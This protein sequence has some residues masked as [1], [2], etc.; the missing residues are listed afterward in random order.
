[1]TLCRFEPALD[2]ASRLISKI[3]RQDFPDAVLSVYRELA[4]CDY[5]ACFSFGGEE[6]PRVIFAQGAHPQIPNFA[7]EASRA[8]AT[9]YWRQDNSWLDKPAPSSVGDVALMRTFAE[10]ICSTEYRR[11]C[12]DRPGI[13]ERLAVFSLSG[14]SYL[15]AGYRTGARG[16]ATPEEKSRVVAAGPT[17]MAAVER[18]C[19]LSASQIADQRAECY[20]AMIEKV[21]RH[22]L[23]EREAHV[24]AGLADGEGQAE[25][26][27]RCDV[28]LSSVIT[29]R[30]RAY[31]KLKVNNRRQLRDFF[32]LGRGKGGRPAH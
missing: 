22:G 27:A 25:I 31:R 20:R 23:S 26:A 28:A 8:Y 19:E 24:V 29:Y 32:E 10:D 7:S 5:C 16:V 9:R 4:G 13:I 30:R 17:L 15:I 12:Y 14:S 2:I 18:H 11:D 6:A 21:K 3:G 1:M